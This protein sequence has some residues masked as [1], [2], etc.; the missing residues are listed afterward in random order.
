MDISVKACG[1]ALS[2]KLRRFAQQTAR[3]R[4]G[5]LGDFSKAIESVR[6]Q[7][8]DKGRAR[9]VGVSQ[10]CRIVLQFKDH[11]FIAV[12]ALGENMVAAVERASQRAAERLRRLPLR[13]GLVIR[14]QPVTAA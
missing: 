12:E 1:V 10:F 6:V 5:G 11:S 8:T 9:G 4:L 14:P 3:E 7:L 13:L 2:S